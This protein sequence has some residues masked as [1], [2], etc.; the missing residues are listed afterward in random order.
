MK[1]TSILSVVKPTK[2]CFNLHN[3]VSSIGLLSMMYSAYCIAV[4]GQFLI[5][6]KPEY[7]QVMFFTLTAM[8][9]ST[10]ILHI[11]VL[12]IYIKLGI[13]VFS[14]LSSTSLFISVYRNHVTQKTFSMLWIL[15]ALMAAIYTMAESI[16][17]VVH[18][19]NRFQKF[20]ISF[21]LLL[22]VFIQSWC[23]FI[24]CIF[25]RSHMKKSRNTRSIVLVNWRKTVGPVPLERDGLVHL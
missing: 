8:N 11:Y 20:L 1:R 5:K 22:T 25:T 21:S 6:S 2:A 24:T 16:V 23:I 3:I 10:R 17:T 15:S 13:Y 19:Q 18:L 12:L 7:V 14:F 4:V 9:I